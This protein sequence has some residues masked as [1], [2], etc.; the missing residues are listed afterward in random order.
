MRRGTNGPSPTRGPT[1]APPSRLGGVSAA[2]PERRPE[3]GGAGSC[4]LIAGFE[5]CAVTQLGEGSQLSDRRRLVV[6][7]G[8]G[9]GVVVVEE[10]VLEAQ[11]GRPVRVAPWPPVDQDRRAVERI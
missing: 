8:E 10:P 1:R 5:L 6:G 7:E 9:R 11:P 3:G 2:N 4:V